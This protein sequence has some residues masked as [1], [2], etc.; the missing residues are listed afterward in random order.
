VNW[1]NLA[2]ARDSGV[3][4]VKPVVNFD[5]YNMKNFWSIAKELMSSQ[6][7]QCTK[8]FF[9]SSIMCSQTQEAN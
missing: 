3:A 4:V 8:E 7:V 1:I 5:L 9:F 2:E 6:E